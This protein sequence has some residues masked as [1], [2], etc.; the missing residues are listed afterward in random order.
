MAKEIQ[1]DIHIKCHLTKKYLV[2]GHEVGYKHIGGV[3]VVHNIS[4]LK[5]V[6]FAEVVSPCNP[7]PYSLI[8]MFLHLNGNLQKQNQKI[9]INRLLSDITLNS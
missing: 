9:L 8:L 6:G 1:K 2:F 3:Q 5:V 4:W 7:N